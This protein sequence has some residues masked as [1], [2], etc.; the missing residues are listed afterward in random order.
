M[1]PRECSSIRIGV[2]N[3]RE[4]LKVFLPSNLRLALNSGEF[5]MLLATKLWAQI[6]ELELEGEITAFARKK[7]IS[8]PRAFFSNSSVGSESSILRK[9]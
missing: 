1:S 2:W 6:S 4:L 8:E 9:L 3:L 7:L 5:W